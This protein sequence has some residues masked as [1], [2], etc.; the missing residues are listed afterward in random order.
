[1]KNLKEEIQEI[2][3]TSNGSEEITNKLL[4][5]FEKYTFKK[6]RETLCNVEKQ[7][8]IEF[9]IFE[10]VDIIPKDLIPELQEGTK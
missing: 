9:N 7:K 2:L 8:G 5:L 4:A 1:M 10:L 3:Y 6:C